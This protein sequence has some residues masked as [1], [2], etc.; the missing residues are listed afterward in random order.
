MSGS[1]Q[2]NADHNI[3]AA[4][5]EGIVE[6]AHRRIAG[7]QKSEADLGVTNDRRQG[8]LVDAKDAFHALYVLGDKKSARVWAERGVAYA[9]EFF[10]GVWRDQ[11]PS[12]NGRNQ[13][14][15]R[16]WQDR[17]LNWVEPLEE[18]LVLATIL[19]RWDDVRR[20]AEFPRDDISENDGIVAVMDACWLYLCG[21]IRGRDPQ[22]L[23]PFQQRVI[24]QGRKRDKL[25]L[26]FVKALA[27]GEGVALQQ[28][29]DEYFKQ[30]LRVETR[31]DMTSFDWDG[32]ILV[33][34]ATHLGYD[35]QIPEKYRK[36]FVTL[37]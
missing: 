14:P 18:A 26:E 15:N 25:F 24:D 33:H 12:G 23:E 11:V 19:E 1:Q 34:Y 27:R 29:A 7:L 8:Y 6:K 4:A 10:F 22:E 9:L 35:L 2:G 17:S 13:P 30:F 31:K 5:V 36:Y 16:E 32:T 37:S 3:D 20:L 21:V 28:A